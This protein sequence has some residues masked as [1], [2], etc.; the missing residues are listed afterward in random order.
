MQGFDLAGKFFRHFG[1]IGFVGAVEVVAK[2]FAFGIK[3]DAKIGG[4][5]IIIEFGEHFDNAM[6]G[7]CGMSFGIGEWGESVKGAKEV[8]GA[9]D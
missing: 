6:K 4:L 7:A 3:D 2:G 8:G 9:V 5:V 1:T